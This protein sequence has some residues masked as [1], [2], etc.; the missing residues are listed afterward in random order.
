MTTTSAASLP[1][2]HAKP[3]TDPV[4]QNAQ[5]GM[6]RV[7]PEAVDRAWGLYVT[8]VG[9][10]QRPGQ[11]PAEGWRLYYLVRGAATLHSERHGH[12][13]IEAGDIVLLDATSQVAIEVDSE[14]GCTAHQIDFCGSHLQELNAAGFFSPLPMVLHSGF[15]EQL[16]GLIAQIIELA[17]IKPTGFHRLLAGVLAN[18][19]ARLDVVRH[20]VAVP[21]PHS[22][23][24]EEARELL[25]DTCQSHSPVHAL[26]LKMGISY[27][28]FRR[29]F[30]GHTGISPHQ[31]RLSQRLARAQQMLT[32]T[33]LPIAKIAADLG[34]TSQAYFARIFRRQ[35]G[36]SPSVWRSNQVTSRR[37]EVVAK[38]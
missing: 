16:L 11:A 19:V 4:Y 12:Q 2:A 38:A 17:R 31:F 10:G 7:I 30:R 23:L 5:S 8:G 20:T 22:R 21:D 18:L 9:Q 26:A 6:L 37:I 1:L 24:V 14:R 29:S 15:N 28:R 27:S 3:T 33:T 13:S 34:F 35:T 36:F 25:V 32:D